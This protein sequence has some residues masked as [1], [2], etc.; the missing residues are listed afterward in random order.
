MRKRLPGHSAVLY[1]RIPGSLAFSD[2][3]TVLCALR[4]A[5][6][7]LLV[8]LS[9]G[10]LKLYAQFNSGIE[11]TVTDPSGAAVPNAT[12]TLQSLDTGST[13]TATSSGAGYYRFNALAAAAFKLTVSANGFKTYVQEN[14]QLQ[15]ANITTINIA[16]P[17]GEVKTEVRVNDVPPPIQ[18]AEADVSSL[19]SKEDVHELPLVGRNFYTLVVLTPGV[20]GLPSGGGQAYAQASADIFN[21]EYGVNMNANGLRAEQNEFS[22]DGVS[23]TSMVRGGVANMNPSADSIQELRV[24]VNTYSAEYG[25][26]GAHVEAITKSGSNKFHGNADWFFTDQVLQAK[27]EFQSSVPDFSRNEYAGALGGPIYRDRTFF[28]GSVDVLRSSVAFASPD[29]VP[30]TD[31]INYMS[32][33]LP[34]NVSTHILTTYPAAVKN[35][36]STQTAGAI[37]GVDCSTLASPSTPI[38]TAAGA[39]PCNLNVLG[40][41]IL[42]ATTPR[43]GLQWGLRGDHV[44]NQSKDRFDVSL[45]RTSVSQVFGSPSAYNPIFT[46]TEPEYTLNAHIDETHAFSASL[47][48]DFLAS[49]VRLNGLIPCTQCSIPEIDIVDASPL[50]NVGN[51]GFIQNNFEY[52]DNLTWSHRA[53]NFK[54]GGNWLKLQSNFNP[55]ANDTRPTFTFTDPFAFAADAPITETGF[56]FNPVTGSENIPTVAERQSIVGAYAQDGW[57]IKPNLTLNLGLRWESFGKV[58]E[59]TEVTNV[60][61]QGGDTFAQQ[62][63]NLKVNVVPSILTQLRYGNFGPRISLAWDPWHDGKTSFRAGFGKFFDPYTAQVYGG[64]HFNPPIAAS[65][66]ASTQQAGPQP[67]FAIG[68]SDTFPYNIPYPTGI[69]L[70]LN[71]HNGLLNSR[72]AITGTDPHLPTAYSENWFLGFQ[73][74]LSRDWVIQADYIGSEG[75]HLYE[76]YDV[77]RFAGDLIQNLGTLT[78]YNPYFSSI[79]YAQGNLNSFYSGSD[80][81]IKGTA[82]HG[83]TTQVAYTFGKAIDVQ[84]S[85]SEGDVVNAANPNAQ[86]GRSDFDA[87]QKLGASIVWQ[88]PG[89]NTG[90]EFLNKGVNGWQLSSVVILQSGT[91]VS[92][93]CSTPFEPVFNTAN[94]AVIGNTGCDYNADGFD[95]DYPNTPSFG[96]KRHADRREFFAGIFKKSDFPT[97]ALG[98]EGNL[99]RNTFEGPGYANTD[100]TLARHFGLGWFSGDKADI[101]FRAEAFNLFN[102]V[103]YSAMS[104]D[105]ASATFGT[106]TATYGARDFQFGARLSF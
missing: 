103:N 25:G 39:V 30:T 28:F 11:G 58:T 41:G 94:T 43:N 102:R 84:S 98:S 80:F 76:L 45:Y 89:L 97:P 70:G 71:S 24:S 54:F 95:Y 68:T 96:N 65:G 44:F 50:G 8:L 101:E 48:N 87:R 90:S 37:A 72:V 56:T 17:V 67:L 52:R 38:Q 61:F 82:A 59:A 21:G 53:H 60:I 10:S 12:L 9:F 36:T 3:E 74:S 62:V 35:F 15:V 104:T 14:I 93:Y 32:A 22:V 88:I 23:V 2:K 105:L 26:A 86:R 7:C 29:T 75:H 16:L 42:N 1:C 79:S 18:T 33:N 85:F 69:Q 92:V 13:Q 63:A 73:R 55:I 99:G 47:L 31:F 19:I 91:P 4:R 78:R 51:V 27:N 81:S 77:N 34:N 49:Y 83:V 40:T 64:S 106:A 20:T 66:V 100:F 6:C 46:N 57:K 5:A